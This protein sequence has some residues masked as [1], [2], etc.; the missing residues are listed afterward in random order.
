MDHSPIRP[1]EESAEMSEEKGQNDSVKKT[2]VSRREMLK[3]AGAVGA[4]GLTALGLDKI[5]RASYTKD[6]NFNGAVYGPDGNPN[7]ALNRIC[8]TPR[9]IAE[10]R[11]FSAVPKPGTV[12]YVSDRG[13]E[14]HFLYD[15]TD[16]V[17]RDNTGLVLVTSS[18]ARFKRLIENNLASVTWFGAKGDGVQDDLDAIQLA[19]DAVAQLPGGNGGTVFF[20]RGV[21]IIAPTKEKCILLRSFVKLTG[22]GRSSV[23][24]VKDNAG[25]YFRIFGSLFNPAVE[26]VTISHLRIDQN[27]RNNLSCN[28]DSSLKNIYQFV[29]GLYNYRHIQIDSVIFDETCGVNTITLNN[30]NGEYASITNC[31]FRFVR[32]KGDP[33]YDN[34]A[35]YVNGR[36]HTVSGCFF[37]CDPKE[38]GRG[39]I[40]THTGQS[41][42][43]NNVSDGYF[44]GVNLQSSATSGTHCDMTI[45]GNT[46]TNANQGIQ[47]W[48]Y[49]NVPIHNVTI[50]GNTISLK[51]LTHLR[52]LTTGISTAGGSA[53]TG[54]FENITITGNTI[55]FEEEFT[56]RSNLGV[57]A[58]G[59]GFARENA[60][61]N[62]VISDNL[63]QN[64]P[65]T[66]IRI[67]YLDKA[68]SYAENIKI[69]GNMIVGAGHYPA[70]S[71]LYR[72]AILL[73]G[74]VVNAQVTDNFISDAYDQPKGLFSIR[75]H[76][77]D[78]SYTNVQVGNNLISTKQGGLWLSLGA[79]VQ[80]SQAGPPVKMTGVF[81]PVRDTFHEGDIVFYNGSSP[82]PGKTTAA[83]VVTKKGTAGTLSGIRAVTFTTD[84]KDEVEVN[85][86][87][88][89]E[90][91]Q[92][93]LVGG[94]S[95][96]IVR[97]SGNLV[98]LNSAIATVALPAAVAWEAPS[99]APFG[100]IGKLA[101]IEDT[102]EGTLAD[103]EQELNKVKQALRDYGVLSAQ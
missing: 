83:Y 71:E 23:I 56:R 33:D 64:A 95:R 22:E 60:V 9:T 89:L 24:K 51:N 100:K 5:T 72:A 36:Y 65:V 87:A 3:Y 66:G 27:A 58:F 26:H 75:V 13:Q 82:A 68:K 85:D 1:Q 34:S 30:D 12:F 50:S 31:T 17:T 43:A 92:W 7:P 32:G 101:P 94:Q 37:Y 4:L 16:T 47:L 70:S 86:A 103:L 20:P 48:P 97:I 88:A 57:N 6:G 10:I 102:A 18:G 45:T 38:K 79:S 46:F 69:T 80:N 81:P 90:T 19:I 52:S 91:E 35:I 40:E 59:I 8:I 55:I 28:I 2:G 44:T 73:R 99:F 63:I 42:I 84:A 96:K 29:V 74:T 21:Y 67:G 15:E 62:I 14:G 53:E 49:K 98:R 77:S 25:D 54:A 76:D 39:A 93:V 41:V 61:K 78:G 11:S